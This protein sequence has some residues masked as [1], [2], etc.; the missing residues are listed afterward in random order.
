M[1]M[2]RWSTRRR[3]TLPLSGFHFS[4]RRAKSQFETP[5]APR[6]VTSIIY[7]QALACVIVHPCRQFSQAVRE[8]ETMG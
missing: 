6:S 5:N 1:G 3:L 4:S 8:S 7:K 2:I